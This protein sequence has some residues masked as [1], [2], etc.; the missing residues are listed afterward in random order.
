MVLGGPGY[1]FLNRERGA[2]ENY[3][4][5]PGARR[6]TGFSIESVWPAMRPGC[7]RID[8]SQPQSPSSPETYQFKVVRGLPKYKVAFGASPAQRL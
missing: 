8:T 6:F 3:D 4:I 1:I 5:K 7:R 2:I